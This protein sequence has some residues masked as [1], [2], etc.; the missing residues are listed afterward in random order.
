MIS[1]KIKCPNCKT[2]VN[3][4]GQ[5]GEKKIIQCQNCSFKG[6]YS[7]PI[8]NN[9]KLN[10]KIVESISVEGLIKNYNGSNAVNNISF[11]VRKGEIFGFLGPN[12][13]GKTTTIKAILGLIKIDSGIIKINNNDIYSNEKIAKKDG[14]VGLIG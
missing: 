6:R 14:A 11:K 3:I 1:K 12:G 2:I 4:E 13:A 8:L 9:Y 5:P 7:F 10:K